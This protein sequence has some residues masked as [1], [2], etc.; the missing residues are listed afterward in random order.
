MLLDSAIMDL[1]QQLDADLW[2]Y[3]AGRLAGTS[4]PVLDELGLVD[5]FL[6]PP[7]FERL[8][9]EDEL[10]ATANDRTAGRPIRVGYK[11]V[12]SGPPDVLGSSPR[13]SCST[14]SV[15][16]SKRR[17]GARTD[18]RHR[19]RLARRGDPGG[20]RGAHPGA[21][22]AAL[23]D[24]ALAVGRGAAPPAF[25]PARHGVRAG[26]HCLPSGWR[27]TCA[28]A[29]RRSRKLGSGPRKVLANVATGVIAVDPELRVTM[30]NPRPKSCSAAV[31][32]RATSSR[33]HET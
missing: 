33:A 11:V 6:A 9:F 25:P 16:G 29:R 24:A 15:C 18:A 7:V 2:L 8:A 4:A 5:P 14:T 20:S 17:P 31:S 32:S 1:G 19:G 3:R 22:V 26:A 23:R 10:E 27:R 30:A 13:R 21:A 12:R 28:A